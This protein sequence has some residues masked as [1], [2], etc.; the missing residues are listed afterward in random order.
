[1]TNGVIRTLVAISVVV[2]L[3][4]VIGLV[5]ADM[6]ASSANDTENDPMDSVG[7]RHE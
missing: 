1:M 2:A 7:G 6:N 4:G 5:S 3:I